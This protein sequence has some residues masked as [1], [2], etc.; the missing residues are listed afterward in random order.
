MT[1]N[2]FEG[3]TPE[4]LR[5]KDAARKFLSNKPI[6]SKLNLLLSPPLLVVVCLLILIAINALMSIYSQYRINRIVATSQVLSQVAHNF[7]VE[8]GLSAG[9]LG[10]KGT[11]GADRVKEQRVKADAAARELLNNIGQIRSY[12]LNP[13]SEALLDDLV[14]S[15]NQRTELRR[16]VDALDP[17][18][19]FFGYYSKVNSHS[20]RLVEQLAVYLDDKAVAST[21][22]ALSNLMWLKERAGQARGAL[23]GTFSAGDYSTARGIQIQQY[24]EQQQFLVNEFLQYANGDQKRFFESSVEGKSN[25]AVQA[26]RAQFSDNFILRQ[27]IDVVLNKIALGDVSQLRQDMQ[28][29]LAL[30]PTERANAVQQILSGYESKNTSVIT[31]LDELK[32]L[33]QLPDVSPEAWFA[34][35]TDRIVNINKTVLSLSSEISTQTLMNILF[36][37][38]FNGLLI[39]LGLFALRF[40]RGIGQFIAI[41]ITDSLESIQNLLASVRSSYQFNTRVD[42]AGNDE[43][44]KTAQDFG[45]LLNTMDTAFSDITELSEALAEGRLADT[46]V[47]NA[48][49]GDIQQLAVNLEGSAD[50]LRDVFTE[51]DR[52][53]VAASRGDFNVMVQGE[54]QGEYLKL[55]NNINTMLK[56]SD[57]SLQ[58]IG[59]NVECLALGKLEQ[60]DESTFNG[61]FAKLVASNNQTVQKLKTVIE[62]D[63]Q[64]LIKNA[65]AGNLSA[66]I[67]TDNKLGC[68]KDL[69]EGINDIVAVNEV[70]MDDV[71]ETISGLANGDLSKTMNGHYLG[72]YATVQNGINDTMHNLSDVIERELDNVIG[73]SVEGDLSQRVDLLGKQGFIYTLGDKINR[74]LNINQN[75]FN[76]I[77]TA[78]TGLSRGD[79]NSQI[80]ADYSGQFDDIKVRV[81]QTVEVL[82]RTI[83]DEIQIVI[84]KTRVGDLSARVP[85]EGKEGCFLLLSDGVNEIINLTENAVDDFKEMI[86][87]LAQGDLIH[88]ITAE[89]KGIFDELKNSS[90]SSSKQLADVMQQIATVAETVQESASQI[91]DA[92]QD[93]STV[94]SSQAASLEEVSS[95]IRDITESMKEN[96]Q[97]ITQA[98]DLIEEAA[99]GS[100]ES[101]VIAEQALQSMVDI[102]DSSK[103][104]EAI[105]GVIDEIAFQTNLLALNA[106]VEAARAG[107]Q[108]KGFTVVASE[109]RNLAQRSA[110]SANEIK[111]LIS[112]SVKTIEEG[113]KQVE[114][115]TVASKKIIDVVAVAKE[116]MEDVSGVI[117]MQESNILQISQSVNEVDNGIQQSSS[118]VEEVSASSKSLANE[119]EKMNQSLAFFSYA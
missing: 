58:R 38:L 103:R 54:M 95:S 31:L 86:L 87:K 17:K 33:K 98:D 70:F 110:S 117:R 96:M 8:R 111:N 69:S 51:V 89:H 80:T 65:R 30:L 57:D 5:D 15:L 45:E 67:L 82:R 13:Q 21:Y 62:T 77:G 34:Q 116:K 35:A 59:H 113:S 72:D 48:Y 39:V 6:K 2:D 99:Q 47:K 94:A 92:N 49:K 27:E 85:E 76:D 20:L 56:D 78:L 66:R 93:L 25:D 7:A 55:K 4:L 23:N 108:G 9:F 53:M 79:L 115:S 41:T 32:L 100:R 71:S 104:I 24:I 3:F 60:A 63:I 44:A 107:E 18:S 19:G 73:A 114:L 50:K 109:V 83:L 90:N 52:S 97:K 75:V 28:P 37:T 10:S 106:A 88:K 119:A 91:A 1:K 74:L 46:K 112:E 22:S 64:E 105:I 84:D 68:F 43:I 16:K 29:V 118:T 81:N 42:I 102:T 11:R 36:T 14:K 61:E 12:T 40:S 101:E 26:M